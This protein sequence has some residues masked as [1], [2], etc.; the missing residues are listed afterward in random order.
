MDCAKLLQINCTNLA[1]ST[2]AFLVNARSSKAQ[3]R[4]LV[5]CCLN[6]PN[7]MTNSDQISSDPTIKSDLEAYH[8]FWQETWDELVSC[9]PND[10]SLCPSLCWP[11]ALAVSLKSLLPFAHGLENSFLRR[12]LLDHCVQLLYDSLLDSP[13]WFVRNQAAWALVQLATRLCCLIHS[14]VKSSHK[15][16]LCGQLNKLENSLNLDEFGDL[17]GIDG[18]VDFENDEFETNDDQSMR[19]G[20]MNGRPDEDGEESQKYIIQV[21][22][23]LIQLIAN[24]LD[25]C[26]PWPGKVCHYFD[27]RYFNL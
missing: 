27:F 14:L 23:I 8:Q 21:W 5:C 26:K 9:I 20:S 1:A 19:I 10:G 4:E 22:L 25:K 11:N 15:S 13:H 7:A 3:I 2:K 12:P 16:N 6:T 17:V 18:S 24:S